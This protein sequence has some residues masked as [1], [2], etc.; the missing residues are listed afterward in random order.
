[1]TTPIPQSITTPDGVETRIDTL[2][3]FD[4]FPD[5]ATVVLF[6]RS[7]RFTEVHFDRT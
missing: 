4:G 3:F 2:K 6:P 1:M 7:L 5:E